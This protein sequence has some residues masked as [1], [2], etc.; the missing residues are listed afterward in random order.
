[1]NVLI[2]DDR[3]E[4]REH[5][6]RFIKDGWGGV[7]ISTA[8]NAHDGFQLLEKNK[9]ALVLLDV[10]LPLNATS[11]PSEEGSIWFIREVKRKINTGLPM[12][13]G[14]TQYSESLTKV[15]DVF[16]ADLW[17]LVHISTTDGRWPDQIRQAMRLSTS[18]SSNLSFSRLTSTSIGTFDVAIVAALKTPEF[19]ELLSAL[20]TVEQIR[21]EETKEAW[22]KAT[23]NRRDGSEVNV[24]AA[25]A[26][27]MGM[28]TMA[29]LV[30]KVGLA[31]RPKKLILIGITAGNKQRTNISDLLVVESSWN[32]QAGKLSEAGFVPDVK[33]IQCSFKLANALSEAVTE[34]FI[35]DFWKNCRI[36]RPPNIA[37]VKPGEVACSPFVTSDPSTFPKLE[38]EQKR[39]ILGLE[40]EA[41]GCYDACRRLGDLA[42]EF[43][44]IKS[45]CDFGDGEKNDKYQ[46]YCASLSAHAVIQAIRL[47]AV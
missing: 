3:D 8:T 18:N 19:S 6:V 20:G 44:C 2:I 15:Q 24:I 43:V 10:V 36:P 5:L 11:T 17:N 46:I 38:Q 28:T 47:G 9:P 31:C 1:M 29:S 23:V 32:F 27:E 16:R 40:M 41:F 7:S 37:E 21:L 14:T 22:V 34:S 45:V 33:S 30:T 42:P 12:I 25:C 4:K 26:N 39:K 35:M 13:V